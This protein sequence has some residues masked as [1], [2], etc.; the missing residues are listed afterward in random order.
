[1]INLGFYGQLFVM[2]LYLQQFRGYSPVR[3]GLALLPELAMAII[4][5]TVSG[6]I[7]A[8]TGPRLPMLAGL[9]LGGAG[10]AGLAAAAG[11]G[12][13]WL[14]AVPMA[15]TGLGMS[16]TMPAATTAGMGSAPGGRAGLAA[17]TV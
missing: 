12:R 4:G 5:S 7:T 1:L 8:R 6:R 11:P 2:T 9:T 13:Y 3:A 15:A 14:L 16:V 10:L 17:G